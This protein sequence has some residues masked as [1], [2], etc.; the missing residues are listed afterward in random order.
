[1]V[2]AGGQATFTLSDGT[3][4]IPNLAA[5]TYT[6]T[7]QLANFSFTPASLPVTIGPSTNNVNFTASASTFTIKGQILFFGTT[8]GFTNAPIVVNGTNSF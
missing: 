1:M 8:N 5:G 3:Y 2:N 7:P 4:S 6:I